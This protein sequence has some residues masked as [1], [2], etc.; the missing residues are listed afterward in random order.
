MH[1]TVKP[2]KCPTHLLAAHENAAVE[3][4][5]PNSHSDVMLLCEHAGNA[6]PASLQHLGLTRENIESH[7]GWD[8][9]AGKLARLIARNLNAPLILQRYSRLV[10]D[11]N[12]PLHSAQSIP[13]LSGGVEIPA[14]THL[15]RDDRLAR[16]TEIFEALDAA[17]V[18]GLSRCQRQAVFSIHS[19]TQQLQGEVRPWHAGFLSRQDLTTASQLMNYIHDQQPDLMLAL[20]EP[21]RIEDASDWFIP[22]HAEPRKL[23]HCLIEVRNDLL[24]NDADIAQWARLLSGAIETVLQTHDSEKSR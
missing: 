13:V 17:I 18:D 23:K 21:Y 4:V 7:I 12:R 20:N 14:N 5:N 8:I 6:I 22:A 3:W 11:C 10:I 15:S 24:R 2:D 9:G 16:H 19:F 1:T